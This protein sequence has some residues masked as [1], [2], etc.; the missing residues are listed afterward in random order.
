MSFLTVMNNIVKHS[1]TVVR[2][3][4]LILEKVEE[5]ERVREKESE[6]ERARER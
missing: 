3:Y 1:V 2:K 5:R 6:R 4:L